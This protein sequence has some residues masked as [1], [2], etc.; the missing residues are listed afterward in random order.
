MKGELKNFLPNGV[1]IRARGKKMHAC[2]RIRNIKDIAHF[3]SISVF[4]IS[5]MLRRLKRCSHDCLITLLAVLVAY[6][7]TKPAG[8]VIIDHNVMWYLTKIDKD[9]DGWGSA[10]YIARIITPDDMDILRDKRLSLY[11]L[12]IISINKQSGSWEIPSQ[13]VEQTPVSTVSQLND[14]AC[15]GRYTPDVGE[16]CSTQIIM[17]H[18]RF[19]SVT[20]DVKVCQVMAAREWTRV[21]EPS[22]VNIIHHK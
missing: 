21:I 11:G 6:F 20:K 22:C 8:A 4:K 14:L 2:A 7:I 19:I 12:Y 16:F 15:P 3:P 5:A 18:V 13:A 9:D 10:Y 17:P 1:V